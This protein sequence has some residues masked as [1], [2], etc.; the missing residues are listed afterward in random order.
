MTFISKPQRRHRWV[1]VSNI[2]WICLEWKCEEEEEEWQRWQAWT[3]PTVAAGI[4]TQQMSSIIK[5]I[6]TSL[7]GNPISSFSLSR[8]H[9]SLQIPARLISD[10]PQA[11][12]N[13]RLVLEFT[14]LNLSSCSSSSSK[15]SSSHSNTSNSSSSSESDNSCSFLVI[16][17]DPPN[18][19]GRETFS[20]RLVQTSSLSDTFFLPPWKTN[21][22]LF[23]MSPTFDIFQQLRI[24]SFIL[25]GRAA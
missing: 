25:L 15:S 19:F 16:D 5:T 23:V 17:L 4:N 2:W 11:P 13:S 22:M 10:L 1:R 7:G 3:L 18:T 8:L 6:I 9:R 14:K 12:L 24:L 20:R 21:A